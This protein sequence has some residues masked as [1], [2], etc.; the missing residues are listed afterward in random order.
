MANKP[1]YYVH[2]NHDLGYIDAP[3]EGCECLDDRV[4]EING[5]RV[6]GLGGCMRYHPGPFQ[7][8]EEEMARRIRRMRRSL[9][10]LQGVDIV[11]THAPPRDLGDADDPAHRGFACFRSLMDEYKPLYLIHGHLH[12]RYDYRQSRSLRYGETTVFNAVDWHIL[13]TEPKDRPEKKAGW[14]SGWGKQ[15]DKK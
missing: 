7:Y 13:E 3:P 9:R 10:R 4:A 6:M 12:P 1:L 15:N 14:K 11:I 2:G 8:T 5:L